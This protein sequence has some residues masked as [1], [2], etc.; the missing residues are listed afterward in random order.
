MPPW[1]CARWAWDSHFE[2]G[3]SLLLSFYI[4]STDPRGA[5]GVLLS[6]FSVIISCK[7]AE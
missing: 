4:T 5:Q 2:R 7:V 6:P 3:K 1:E